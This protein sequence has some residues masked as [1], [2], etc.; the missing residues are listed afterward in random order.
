VRIDLHT[1]SSCSDGTDPPA[2]LVARAA[3]AGVDVLGLTDHDT[4]D[5]WDEA[6]DEAERRGIGLI[7][8]AEISCRLHGGS[9]HLLAYLPDPDDERLTAELARIRAGR[10]AR[11]P[12]ILDRL[13]AH[14]IDLDV[15]AVAAQSKDATSLGRP[16]I[17][18]ALVAAGYV[19]DR[20]EA[21]DRWLGEGR[22]G[23]V[24]RYAPHPRVVVERVVDAGGVP[25]LAHPR[26]RHS[27]HLL[28]DEAIAELAAAG[29]AGLEVD[30]LDH[31]ADVRRELR[32][33][34]GALDLVVTGASDHHGTGKVGHDLGCCTTSEAELVRLLERARANAARAGRHTPAPLL[35]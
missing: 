13:R 18:D 15:A 29:L 5:G 30:H 7:R 4:F 22:P 31:D 6:V 20:R 23:F 16:H 10:D 26:G 32:A 17:A 21:F 3:A 34:A 25:V 19:A 24:T 28:T 33:L 27:R 2:T 9:V 8:G 1:H 35:P 11:V 12:L 14:G